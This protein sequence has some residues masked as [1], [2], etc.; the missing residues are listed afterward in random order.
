M[1]KAG[2]SCLVLTYV[3][4]KGNT[5][6]LLAKKGL[7]M[8]QLL[9]PVV[10]LVGAMAPALSQNSQTE[11][12]TVPAVVD[13]TRAGVVYV[14]GR[15]LGKGDAKPVA[16]A[17]VLLLGAGKNS[18]AKAQTLQNGSFALKAPGPGD[19]TLQATYRQVVDAV[20]HAVSFKK[21]ISVPAIGI[22]DLTVSAETA[23]SVQETA[24]SKDTALALD[25][26]LQHAKD[27]AG[28]AWGKARLGALRVRLNQPVTV[29]LQDSPLTQAAEALTKA[30]G[31]SV[32]IDKNVDT[33]TSVSLNAEGV[34]LARVLEAIAQQTEL[35]IAPA[36]HPGDANEQPLLP[37]GEKL[38]GPVFALPIMKTLEFPQGVILRPW[39]FLE[40]DG[41]KTVEKG[42]NA[43]WSDDWRPPP[44][45]KNEAGSA[46]M[47]VNGE[48][49]TGGGKTPL[50][51]HLNSSGMGALSGA[52]SGLTLTTIGDHLLV[53]AQLG[54]GPAGEP[55]VWLALFKLDGDQLKWLS[56]T[57]HVLGTAPQPE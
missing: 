51:I 50:S 32:R 57:F 4:R 35:M 2:L 8:N 40:V 31:V 37:Q 15:V 10:V 11:P 16:D 54:T 53:A 12:G 22:Q 23:D 29:Q 46:M 47:M 25:D 38:P 48:P 9:I 1:A 26:A 39:P 45:L 42:A 44:T 7:V 24:T 5:T 30:S 6:I 52:A 20:S 13:S 56:N 41:K 28:I 36:A 3:F 55:G 14:S 21:R 27:G 17:D 33:K 34:S 18:V 43:P 49:I 19:Y